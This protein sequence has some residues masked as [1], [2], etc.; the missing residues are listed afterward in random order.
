MRS[1]LVAVVLVALLA[2]GT[3]WGDS[4]RTETRRGRRSCGEETVFKVSLL[5]DRGAL[6]SSGE[7]VVT[8]D[9]FG[10]ETLWTERVD[11]AQGNPRVFRGTLRKPGFLRLSVDVKGVRDTDGKPFPFSVPYENER[12]VPGTPEPADFDAFWR[13]TLAELGKIPEDVRMREEPSLTTDKWTMYR[14]SF[15]TL[16]DRRLHCWLSIPKGEGPWPTRVEIPGAGCGKWS[17]QMVGDARMIKMLVMAFPFEPSLDMKENERLYAE[18]NAGFRAK[19]GVPRYPFAGLGVSREDF[20]FR[21][22]FA[23]AVRAV[24][25]LAARPEVNRTRFFYYGTSQGGGSGFALLALASDIFT[26][27]RMNVPAITDVL[28]PLAGHE[29]GWPHCDWEWKDADAAKVRSV[30]PYF[31]ACNFAPRIKCPVTVVAGLSD[32]TCPAP[33]ICAA[34]NRIASEGSRLILAYGGTHNTANGIANEEIAAEGKATTAKRAEGAARP[35][36]FGTLIAPEDADY[37]RR[38]FREDVTDPDSGLREQALED[39]SFRIAK[40]SFEGGETWQ[41]AKARAF[42]WICEQMGVSCSEHDIFPAISCFRR[43]PRPIRKAVCWRDEMVNRQ[44][45]SKET[46]AV[47]DGF[48]SGKFAMWKDFDHSVPAWDDLLAGGWPMMEARLD[49]Y[50]K[51]TPYYQALRITLKGVYAALDRFAAAAR[52][53]ATKASTPEKRARLEREAAAFEHIR[54]APPR[55]AYEA[56]VFQWSYFF[57]SEHVDNLQVRALGALDILYTP[58]YRADLAA[59][60]L[61]PESFKRDLAHFW[62]QWGSVD[63]YWGQPVA[64]G[65]TKADGSTEYNEVSD[66]ILDVHDELALPTPKML[67]KIATNTPDRVF[68][69][70]LG[71]AARNRSMTFDGEE[72]LARSLKAWRHCTDEECR[73]CDLNGCYEFYIHASQNLT[74]SSH[75]SFLQPIADLLARAKD[76]TFAAAD[77]DAFFAA[78]LA[79]L[80]RNT[81]ECCDLTDAWEKYLGDINPG[82]VYSLATESAVRDGKDAFS[83]GFR[84][85]DTALLSVGLGTAVDALLAVKEIVY[86]RK[87]MSLADLGALMAANWQGGEELRRRMLRSKRKWGNNEPEANRTGAAIVGQ[88]GSWVNGRPNARGGIWGFSGHPA[89][90]FIVLMKQTGATPD[91]RLAGEE[92][93]K[94]LSPT[95]GADTEG[96][97]ALINTLSNLKPEDLPTN[98]PLDVQMLPSSVQGAAGLAAMRT[99]S[100]VYFANG[101]QTIQ[102][103]VFDIEAL[104]DA[105]KRPWRYENL[106]VRVCGWNVRWNDLSKT[107]QDMYIRRAENIAQ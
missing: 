47:R 28:G 32:C 67:V 98:F 4:I 68:D 63:N 55:T 77:Y 58:F 38:K 81:L 27:G 78:Y 53:A 44:Y 40:E 99:L 37:V 90:Q 46:E 75:I 30:I 94:N 79:E 65:G 101:G 102:F 62:W 100:R 76:G 88:I 13:D 41:V 34:Y 92:S 93:S 97:T 16:G 49:K 7:G 72:A 85:N 56:L 83:T 84:F 25:W 89:R 23:G 69:R 15:A 64:L 9:D 29:G 35:G 20:F 2:A 70:M 24:R 61:T 19:Y 51:G 96:V 14:L 3:A 107:E 43:L 10:K 59:G 21:P 31:D 87:E 17:T 33:G 11:F 57:L 71:M 6:K 82:N 5:D 48:K 45:L 66:L 12:I 95:M 50:D 39:G 18:M 22:V 86:E 52:A 26:D 54:R 1:D 80:R 105:Q 106:Q 74:Q 8:L 73:T 42:A 91:G 103:N 36:A 60:R 104:K